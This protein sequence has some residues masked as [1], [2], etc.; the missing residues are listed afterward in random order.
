MPEIIEV[1]AREVFDSRGRPTVEAE[2]RCQG[3]RPA[4]AIAPS[5]ASTGAAEAWE[6]RDGGSRLNGLGVRH[7]VE[8]V[9]AILRPALLGQ[10]AAD[11]QAVDLLMCQLDGTANKSRLGANAILACS[12]VTAYACAEAL[13]RQP[14]E[15]FQHLWREH[16]AAPGDSNTPGT[17]RLGERPSLPMPMVNM[18]SGGLHAGRNLDF[19]DFLIIP[20]GAS[21]YSESLDWI[22]EIYLRLG[23]ALTENGLEG[24]LV[25]DEGGYGPKLASAESALDFIV[26][27]IERAG[28]QPRRDVALALDVASTHFYEDGTYR[29]ST[30]GQ[31]RRISS[32]EMI[33]ELS[34][35]VETYPILSVEDGLAEDDWTG[36][37][38]LTAR[39]GS[40][41]Q[42][43]GDDLFATN[44]ERLGRGISA[45]V[46]NSVLIKLNQIGTL[47][48][49]FA[50]MRLALDHGYL[51]VI[52][53]RSGE[54]EDVTI[55][56]LAVATGAGQI[57]IGSVARGE[58]LA[59]YNQL[60]RLEELLGSTTPFAGRTLFDMLKG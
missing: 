30:N 13:G 24:V 23:K 55:A 42:L 11:Q 17:E 19:Q 5:G 33:E 56:D 6:L 1:Q 36:W 60:L 16:S 21:R 10:D 32:D 31:P 53:A 59:K 35:L 18:I 25:G 39:L 20:V 3:G 27:S 47:S 38:R 57:K 2:V 37:E 4:R 29:L 26:Q 52:S 44:A 8:N 41:V 14:V 7:A 58:R 45:R 51:P 46:A 54:T 34:R 9:N 48:E 15:H 12:L 40:R 28:L 49:T 43:I 22:I 50:A